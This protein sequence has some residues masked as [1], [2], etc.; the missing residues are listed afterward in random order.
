MKNKIKNYF[1]RLK[2]NLQRKGNGQLL[3]DIEKDIKPY[4]YIRGNFDLLKCTNHIDFN[5]VFDVGT[6]K[7]GAALYFANQGKHK[8]QL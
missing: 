4:F 7:G 5:T 8:L 1:N 3:L 6:G 2:N